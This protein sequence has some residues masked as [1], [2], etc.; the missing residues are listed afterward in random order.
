[1]N[2]PRRLTK[3]HR[4]KSYPTWEPEPLQLPQLPRDEPGQRPKREA[5]ADAGSPSKVIII[6]LD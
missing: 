4:D 3:V 6:D 1:M 5:P 2:R